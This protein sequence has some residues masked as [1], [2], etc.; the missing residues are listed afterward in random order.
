[1][2]LAET[3][4]QQAAACEQLGSPLYAEL[5]RR[6]VDDY[7]LGG[8]STQ[9]LERHENDPGPSALALRLLGSAHRMVLAGEAPELA[10]FYPSVGG[11]WD[12]VP[13]WRAFEQV[14]RARGPELRVLLNQPP[15]TNEV[16]RSV[17]LY[18]GLL[19]LAESVPL[20]IRLFETGSS[21]GLNLRADHFRYDLDDGNGFGPADSPVQFDQAWSGRPIKPVSPPRIVQRTGCDVAP[22][23]PLSADG[24]LTLKS[25]VWP[26]MTVRL[27]RLSGALEVAR[28]VPADVRRED[29][30]SFLEAVDTAE[31]QLGVSGNGQ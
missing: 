10:A 2:H 17:A 6:V 11:V 22:I 25:Y 9:V 24:V 15:Q 13:G 31:G 30:L 27:Q 1:V 18:G 5:L 12:P 3:F 4:R 29:V 26:D 7:E 8:V 20:P 28:Q 16:G 21:A 23:N 14:L 19:W